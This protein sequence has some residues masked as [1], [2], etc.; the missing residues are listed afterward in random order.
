M[1]TYVPEAFRGRGVAALL[2]QVFVSFWQRTVMSVAPAYPNLT[3]CVCNML[4]KGRYHKLH[5]Q[6]CILETFDEAIDS[7]GT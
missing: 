1:S 5:G 6:K 3:L 2:S 7:R 4:I